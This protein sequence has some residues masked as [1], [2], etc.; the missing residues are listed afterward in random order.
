VSSYVC[1]EAAGWA[2]PYQQYKVEQYLFHV[3]I[4]YIC[5]GIFLELNIRNNTAPSA[6]LNKYILSLLWRKKYVPLI[7]R[8]TKE[9]L[10]VLDI[11]R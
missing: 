6:Y 8:I 9:L 11:I 2:T 1:H 5:V 10:L 4:F 7:D 3:T